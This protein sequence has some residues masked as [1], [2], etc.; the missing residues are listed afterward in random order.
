MPRNNKKSDEM[1]AL[2]ESINVPVELEETLDIMTKE[3]KMGKPGTAIFVVRC[4]GESV[5]AAMLALTVA[6]NI[7][8]AAYN[9]L[10]KIPLIGPLTKIVVFRDYADRQKNAQTEIEVPYIAGLCVKT[11]GDKAGGP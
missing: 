6:A 9:T 8:A 4:I 10:A 2:Y 7:S 5:I 11:T 1:R 3:N